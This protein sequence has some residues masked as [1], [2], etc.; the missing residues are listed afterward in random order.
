MVDFKRLQTI[1]LIIA[2]GI[3][4]FL[5]FTEKS[6]RLAAE[7]TY[8]DEKKEELRELA[9]SLHTRFDAEITA[10]QSKID[11]LSSIEQDI[12]YVPYEKLRYTDI[13]VDTALDTIADYSFD[14]KSNL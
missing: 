13:T 5:Y 7:S 11:Y 3:F 4:G 6:D 2:V 1:V 8:A 10:F 9:D 12:K 14:S